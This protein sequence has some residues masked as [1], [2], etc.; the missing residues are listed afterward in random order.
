VAE[1]LLM[2]YNP[3]ALLSGEHLDGDE[4]YIWIRNRY[5]NDQDMDAGAVLEDGAKALIETGI[6]PPDSRPEQLDVDP[7]VIMNAYKKGP[8]LQGHIIDTAW[9]NTVDGRIPDFGPRNKLGGHCTIGLGQWFF[10]D[11][12]AEYIGGNS[13]GDTWGNHGRFTMG[14]N[15]FQETCVDLWRI[16][17]NPSSMATWSG[18]RKFIKRVA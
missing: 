8:I 6:L 15:K 16:D 2:S 9:N 3:C 10:E 18:H 1:I 11:R 5:Y 12:E 14:W 17:V 4:L 13:W 7:L